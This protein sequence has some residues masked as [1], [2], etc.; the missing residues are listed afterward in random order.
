MEDCAECGRAT[1]NRYDGRVM[2]ADCETKSRG[3]Q[4]ERRHEGDDKHGKNN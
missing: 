2:C 3:S 4:D 1:E